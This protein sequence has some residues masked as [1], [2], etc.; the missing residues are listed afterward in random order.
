MASDE[1]NHI[2]MITFLFGGIALS[3]LLIKVVYMKMDEYTSQ[4]QKQ[5]SLG[6]G[7][8]VIRPELTQE[9]VS[10]LILNIEEFNETWSNLSSDFVAGDKNAKG[11]FT[12]QF[13]DLYKKYLELMLKSE[14]IINDK[15]DGLA[16]KNLKTKQLT[17]YLERLKGKKDSIDILKEDI[18][19]TDISKYKSVAL[20]H[21]SCDKLDKIRKVIVPEVSVSRAKALDII[22]NEKVRKLNGKLSSSK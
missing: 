3:G 8:K 5:R 20:S 9:E 7:W 11:D 22:I 16:P 14:S 4:K 10:K 6:S 2:Q 17:N 12:K 1:Y 15:K 21:S 19:M 13:N 18:Q